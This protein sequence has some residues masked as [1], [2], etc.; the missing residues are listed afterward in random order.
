MNERHPGDTPSEDAQET[1]ARE[2]LAHQPQS[3]EP[4]KIKV[5][6]LKPMD[7]EVRKRLAAA[8]VPSSE[9]RKRARELFYNGQLEEA[10]VECRRAIALLPISNGK[11]EDLGEP[12]LLGEILVEQ[13][14]NQEAIECLREA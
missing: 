12:S 9:A 6:L 3:I 10:E 11:P 14:R 7:P 1:E 8:R 4:R 5:V 13:G 2:H